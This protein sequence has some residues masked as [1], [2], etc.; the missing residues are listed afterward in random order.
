M[1]DDADDEIRRLLRSGAPRQANGKVVE[2]YREKLLRYLRGHAP[3]GAD[4]RDLEG[5]T[6]EGVFGALPRFPA[7]APIIALVIGVARHKVANAFGARVHDALPSHLS[8]VRE[9]FPGRGS[10]PAT[11]SSELRRQERVERIRRA[12]AQL[13]EQDRELLDLRWVQ[14]LKPQAIAHVL[15]GGVQ[16][17]TVRQRLVAAGKRFLEKLEAEPSA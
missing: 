11:P 14:D 17:V 9:L 8:E 13:R 7:D 12:L 1:A 3:S 2:V 5:A 6:W 15:G 4:L 16:S 10:A